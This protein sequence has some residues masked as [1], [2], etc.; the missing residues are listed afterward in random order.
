MRNTS[1]SDAEKRRKIN[2]LQEGTIIARTLCID[3]NIAIL[4]GAVLLKPCA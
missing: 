4:A 1:L 3:A 2:W